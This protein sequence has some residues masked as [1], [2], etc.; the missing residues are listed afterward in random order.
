MND[1]LFPSYNEIRAWL[2]GRITVEQIVAEGIDGDRLFD[3]QIEMLK[4]L[5]GRMMGGDEL[6]KY[7]RPDVTS[8]TAKCAQAGVALVRDGNKHRRKALDNIET[9]A[10]AVIGA[11]RAFLAENAWQEVE[12]WLLLGHDLPL[13][14]KWKEIARRS[15]PRSAIICPSPNNAVSSISPSKGGESSLGRRLPGITEFASGAAKT[16]RTWKSRITAWLE[17]RS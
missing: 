6:W 12:V 9:H 15:T 5:E 8:E 10:Q 4:R 13:G 11:S 1:D 14:W 3:F 7:C 17:Q 2:S 16:F